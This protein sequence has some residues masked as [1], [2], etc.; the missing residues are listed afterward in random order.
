VRG[1]TSLFAGCHEHNP[2]NAKE[3]NE[4]PFLQRTTLIQVSAAI[5]AAATSAVIV[6][7]D[8][9]PT[10]LNNN[11]H[12]MTVQDR[13]VG[14]VIHTCAGIAVAVFHL[15]GSWWL[16]VAGATWFSIVLVSAAL[17]WW[18]P[19]LFGASP[20]EVDS[21]TFMQE[22]SG[23]V[24][25]LPRI[26]D[27]VVVPDVQHMLIHASVLLSCIL[28]WVSF[29][30][31]L[32]RRRSGARGSKTSGPKKTLLRNSFAMIIRRALGTPLDVMNRQAGSP[33]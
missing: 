14:S 28:S 26:A 3:T 25:V 5:C 18:V 22:Y 7:M 24:S 13:L 1:I 12:E 16:I 21:E 23:N 33:V 32:R 4:R 11:I 30:A 6:F 19:Y 27:H 15:S 2:P 31:A 10:A 20:W 9:V 29:A 17:N 8:W